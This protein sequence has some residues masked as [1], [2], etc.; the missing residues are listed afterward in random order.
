MEGS[1][2]PI[3][4]P[5]PCKLAVS[6]QP[7]YLENVTRGCR[8]QKQ[9]QHQQLLLLLLCTLQYHYQIM[10]SYGSWLY[11]LTAERHSGAETDRAASPPL[12]RHKRLSLPGSRHLSAAWHVTCCLHHRYQPQHVREVRTRRR[13]GQQARQGQNVCTASRQVARYGWLPRG[14]GVRDDGE[15]LASAG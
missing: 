4:W 2:N 12:W 8:L 5:S 11:F 6:W 1:T 15:G 14:G 10:L 3:N 9:H 7:M 13:N